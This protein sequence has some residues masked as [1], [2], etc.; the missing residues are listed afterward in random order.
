MGFIP[1]WAG[2]QRYKLRTHT[3]C[4][5]LGSPPWVWFL[6]PP[7]ILHS[8]LGPLGPWLGEEV[9]GRA[10]GEAGDAGRAK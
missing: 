3:G 10:W 5:T 7:T 1:P 6:V 2:G 4:P 9:M 8:P